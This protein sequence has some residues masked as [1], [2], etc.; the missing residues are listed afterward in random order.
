MIKIGKVLFI[1]SYG[2]ERNIQNSQ[3]ASTVPTYQFNVRKIVFALRLGAITLELFDTMKFLS[4][5]ADSK[6]GT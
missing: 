3:Y 4:P 2:T 1:R 6:I 5:I